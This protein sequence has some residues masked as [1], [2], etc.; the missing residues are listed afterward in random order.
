M[1]G[2]L[3]IAR[4]S[5]ALQARGGGVRFETTTD[6]STTPTRGETRGTTARL[7]RLHEGG[8]EYAHG[9]CR[10]DTSNCT[11]RL[12]DRAGPRGDLWSSEVGG[13]A[14]GDEARQA[15]SGEYRRC[16]AARWSVGLALEQANVGPGGRRGETDTRPE[17]ALRSR[18]PLEGGILPRAP[19]LG[20]AAFPGP[21][22]RASLDIATW[23]DLPP[24]SAGTKATLPAPLWHSSTS[25]TASSSPLAT[26]HGAPFAPPAP[27]PLVLARRRRRDKRL[28]RGDERL[29]NLVQLDGVLS[30]SG[31]PVSALARSSQKKKRSE[32][33][34]GERTHAPDLLGQLEH[35]LLLGGADPARRGDRL[36]VNH[37]CVRACSSS[38]TQARRKEKTEKERGATHRQS[39][40]PRTRCRGCRQSR[41]P[42]FARARGTKSRS[43]SR[44]S[45]LATSAW[46]DRGMGTV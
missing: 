32:R 6:D 10:C 3:W 11:L 38:A 46:A 39:C 36:R 40:R 17:F 12:G 41:R 37:D 34:R 28:A 9:G 29:V 20:F 2:D 44:P 30:V 23:R 13:K 8:T 27:S 25:E 26:A 15:T 16:A 43:S 5:Q 45:A 7:C 35:D 1:V 42:P 14:G 31:H 24:V 19:S 33:K 21:V 22:P 18:R 4:T